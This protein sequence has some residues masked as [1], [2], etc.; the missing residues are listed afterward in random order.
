MKD[1]PLFFFCC[2]EQRVPSAL[3]C[4]EQEEFCSVNVPFAV[5]PPDRLC[6]AVLPFLTGRPVAASVLP[7]LSVVVS[8]LMQQSVTFPTGFLLLFFSAEGRQVRFLS[9]VIFPWAS[10]SPAAVPSLSVSRYNALSAVSPC[11]ESKFFAVLLLENSPFSAV[12]SVFLWRNRSFAGFGKIFLRQSLPLLG[13]GLL[14]KELPFG[15]SYGDLAFGKGGF[16]G[17]VC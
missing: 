13:V 6:S 12:Y 5:L 10:L 11:A 9:V 2:S 8:V 17:K 7:W 3:L 14:C 4:T 15:L 1:V 16:C